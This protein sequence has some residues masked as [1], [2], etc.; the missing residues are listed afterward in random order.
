MQVCQM[1]VRGIMEPWARLFE[2]FAVSTRYMPMSLCGEALKR[3]NQVT[4]ANGSVGHCIG[5]GSVNPLRSTNC[6]R[7]KM[8]QTLPTL[9]PAHHCQHETPD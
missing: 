7:Q 3:V 2:S 4:Y 1:F 9:H 6:G 8:T 5:A